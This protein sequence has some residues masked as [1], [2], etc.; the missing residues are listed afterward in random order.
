MQKEKNLKCWSVK[1]V[2]NYI[3]KPI[4]LDGQGNVTISGTF[5]PEELEAI[6]ACA[7]MERATPTFD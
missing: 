4:D 1:D 3:G 6:T 7:F 5:N 2:S